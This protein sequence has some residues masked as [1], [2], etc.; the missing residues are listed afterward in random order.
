MDAWTSTTFGEVVRLKKSIV[1]PKAQDADLPYLGLEHFKLDGG[2]HSIGKQSDASGDKFLFELGHTLYGRLRPY[3][4][5]TYRAPF[6]GYCSTEIWVLEPVDPDVLHPD[7]LPFIV[8]NQDF[9]DFAMSGAQGTKMPRAVWEHVSRYALVLPPLEIQK[10]IAVFLGNLVKLEELDLAQ[11]RNLEALAVSKLENA[12]LPM[13]RLGDFAQSPASKAKRFTGL[14]A[15]FSL[16][17]FDIDALPEI[18]DASEIK[19]NKVPITKPV[20][21]ASRLNPKTPRIWMAYPTD[22]CP[23]AAST[24]FVLLE[25]KEGMSTEVVWTTVATDGFTERLL[26]LVTGTTGSHQRVDKN[27]FIKVPVPDVRR[28]PE[29]HRNAISALVKSA[30]QLRLEASATHKSRESLIPLLLSG[31][32]SLSEAEG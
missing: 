12:D 19:S 21:L 2:I 3:F 10:S 23:G 32:V 8:Q 13:V 22:E 30:A 5:K 31:S 24:E 26:E 6:E 15:H 14:V 1:K 4:R 25:G 7:L 16:P 17:A 18:V 29:A 20:V 28:L 11:A 27:D 9:T